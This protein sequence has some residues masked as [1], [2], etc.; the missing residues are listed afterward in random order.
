ML[1][2]RFV[3]FFAVCAGDTWASELGCLASAPPRL[4]TAPWRVVPPGTNGGRATERVSLVLEQYK[5]PVGSF[6][7]TVQYEIVDPRVYR[8]QRFG[9]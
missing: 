5:V 1:V 6:E 7:F 2:A 9:E 3:A 8:A 4:V